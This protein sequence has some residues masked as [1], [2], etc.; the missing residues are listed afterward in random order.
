MITVTKLLQPHND[1][2]KG[3]YSS[4][5]K[6]II[7]VLIMN[8]LMTNEQ[9]P[10]SA[11][12]VLIIE[13]ENLHFSSKKSFLQDSG[14]KVLQAFDETSALLII[15][16]EK[17]DILLVD[18][19]LPE[20]SVINLYQTLRAEYK[21]P[22]LVLT[23]DP[24]E[25]LQVEALDVGID[26]YLI[27]PVSSA[28]LR[29]RFEA[30]LRRVKEPFYQ[31]VPNKVQVGGITLF[32]LAQKCEVNNQGVHLSTFEFRLLG[33]LLANVGQIMSRDS[34]YRTLL[35]REY[36]GEERTV[37]VRVSKLRDKLAGVGLA[38]AKIE[39]VWGKGYILNEIA[40]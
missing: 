11:R 35:G 38:H 15:Q 14:Y 33:L 1:I 9:L 34:I 26:D 2:N 3:S 40:A 21:G 19:T 8:N 6:T 31:G 22:I 37:D 13:G 20:K 4:P 27:K 5:D 17:P 32:P 23:N 29:A 16:E 7:E 18:V 28:I 24:I 36:N 12:T 10:I 25:K 30:L 39:T